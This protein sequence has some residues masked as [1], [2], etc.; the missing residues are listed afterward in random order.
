MSPSKNASGRPL[1]PSDGGGPEPAEVPLPLNTEL[2]IPINGEVVPKA[3]DYLVVS[4]DLDT[5]GRR[6]I[7]EICQI[8]G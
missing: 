6:L 1:S 3:D 4:W 2:V 7:D 5:T 8:G